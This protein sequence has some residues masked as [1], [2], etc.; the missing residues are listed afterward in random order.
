MIRWINSLKKRQSSIRHLT[1]LK[2]SLSKKLDHPN[3]MKD[4]LSASK[5]KFKDFKDSLIN[6]GSSLIC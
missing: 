2:I 5:I 1:I 6:F 3:L 4:R